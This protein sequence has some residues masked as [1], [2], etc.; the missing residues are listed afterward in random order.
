MPEAAGA[1][2]RP[3]PAAS[4][5]AEAP[6][7]SDGGALGPE[8]AGRVF[9]E[10]IRRFCED[11]PTER[12]LVEWLAPEGAIEAGGVQ[13][14]AG[15]AFLIRNPLVTSLNVGDGPTSPYVQVA[16]WKNPGAADEPIRELHAVADAGGRVLPYA[17]FVAEQRLGEPTRTEQGG[18]HPL[19]DLLHH[20]EVRCGDDRRVEVVLNE[21]VWEGAVVGNIGELSLT[22][23]AA[24]RGGCE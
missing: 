5:G 15:R 8:A 2:T 13:L 20:H 17:R 7:V 12:E 14:P 3:L 10:L 1:P 6:A 11:E 19:A 23:P 22:R 21:I 24:A 16:W 18:D 4:D 9:A